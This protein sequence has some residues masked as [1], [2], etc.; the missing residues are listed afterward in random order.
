V[1]AAVALGEHRKVQ[2][3]LRE[4]LAEARREARG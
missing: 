2:D 4:I 1:A 3:D